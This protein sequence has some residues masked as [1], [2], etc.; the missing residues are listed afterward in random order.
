MT[1]T[2]DKEA[3]KAELEAFKQKPIVD[4]AVAMGWQVMKTA[5][6]HNGKL[7]KGSMKIAPF[8][9]SNAWMWKA[10]SGEGPGGRTAGT[11]VD[12]AIDEA[13]SIGKARQLLRSLT[14][15]SAPTSIS[16]SPASAPTPD[17]SPSTGPDSAFSGRSYK[18]SDEVLAAFK[19]GARVWRVGDRLPPHMSERGVRELPEIFDRTFAVTTDNFRNARFPLVAY[20]DDGNPFYAGYED[21]NLP[22]EPGAKSY[23]RYAK[24]ARAGVWH[25]RGDQGAPVVITESPLDA[26]SY[27]ILRTE[28]RR[29]DGPQVSY[30]AVRSGAERYAVQGI[31]RKTKNGTKSVIIAT[32]QDA[33]GMAYAAKIMSGIQELKDDGEIESDVLVRYIPPMEVG[34][35]MHADWNDAL[36]AHRA[37]EFRSE[38]K[39][40]GGPSPRPEPRPAPRRTVHPDTAP[41]PA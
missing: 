3:A 19:T 34:G 6:K 15:T 20:D 33:A 40:S 28:V 14:G 9:G 16:I 1:S 35:V 38:S 13:G 7:K 27:E 11:V 41:C 31:L 23:R 18:T 37:Q 5:D 25:T 30:I 24:D 29:E 2:Y 36:M 12:L 8:K 21:R 26:I 4:L 22:P 32:H 17:T 39:S 10:F